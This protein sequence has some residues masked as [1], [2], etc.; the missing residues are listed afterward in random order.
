MLRI[1]PKYPEPTS[2][3]GK[4]AGVSDAT[5]SNIPSGSLMS[6]AAVSFLW[7]YHKGFILLNNT[8]KNAS[9]ENVKF[10]G[11]MTLFVEA[12]KGPRYIKEQHSAFA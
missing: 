4:A 6:G 3:C 5:V 2:A 1:S 9:T 11:I 8:K 12:T 10:K 7:G